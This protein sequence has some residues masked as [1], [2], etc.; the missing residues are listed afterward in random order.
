MQDEII[1][2]GSQQRFPSS[3]KAANSA[4]KVEAATMSEVVGSKTT[5]LYGLDLG[6]DRV[7]RYPPNWTSGI[8]SMRLGP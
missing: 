4:C 1:P 2:S 6:I 8:H 3:S 7:G 5:L